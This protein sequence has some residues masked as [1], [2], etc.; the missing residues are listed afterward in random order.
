[1]KILIALDSSSHSER[2]L[3][4]V[5]RMRW[6]AGSR[7]IV[8]S[9]LPSALAASLPGHSAE[10]P[11]VLRHLEEQRLHHVGVIERAQIVLRECGNPTEG[12]LLEGDAREQLLQ[13]VEDER[14][15]LLVVGSRG[16]GHLARLMLG[17]VSSHA[18]T[19]S[20]CS[21]LVVKPYA[22]ST[23][24]HRATVASHPSP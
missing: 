14:V 7:M 13:L 12:R 1:M 21:V 11:P 23:P 8:A 3:Q 4:F 16:H 9:V 15:D 24:R 6:P 22:R 18:V 10:G 17:S 19:H 2:A 20:R 5:T